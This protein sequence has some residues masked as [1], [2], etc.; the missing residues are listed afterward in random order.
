MN[1][2]KFIIKI[3]VRVGFI[4]ITSFLFIWV[5]AYDHLSA[6]RFAISLALILQTWALFHY[7]SVTNRNLNNFL[8][9]LRYL[10]QI[11]AADLKDASFDELNLTF[12]QIIDIVKKAKLDKAS[13]SQYFQSTVEHV[14]IGLISY[15]EDGTIEIFNQAALEIFNMD[16]PKRW[17]DF[18]RIHPEIK[19][20][21]SEMPLH[22]SML[23]TFTR[24]GS[25][26]KLS[27]RATEFKLQSIK[28]RLISL[29]NI[30]AELAL[31]ELEAWQKLIR[32]LTH[33]ITN[34]ITP[35]KSL[36]GT[37]LRMFEK[38]HRPVAPSSIKPETVSN[39]VVGLRTIQKQSK[40]L[41][42]FV[43]SYRSLTKLPTPQ[44]GDI[45]ISEL[46]AELSLLMSQEID[47]HSIALN[48]LCEP[49]TIKCIGDEKLLL[50][51]L[52]NLV[53]NAIAALVGIENPTIEIWVGQEISGKTMI[54]ISD[55][56]TGIPDDLLDQI[57]VPFYTTRAEGWGIGLSLSRQIMQLHKG[58]LEAGR[59]PAGHTVFNLNF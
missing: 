41:V 57:F 34:S 24:G 47:K 20:T 36:V 42:D 56:G 15:S 32:V 3:L 27:A 59:N 8:L 48:V 25:L 19:K 39:A 30:Q 55:N 21:L 18:E 4:S 51:V 6:T 17:E 35:I 52:I 29:Q 13:E 43:G 46:L 40:R 49:P 23:I 44:F 33:E 1:Y 38:D 31:G 16:R 28:K 26:L 22:E 45:Q 10:D 11:N 2:N 14:G 58:S 7:V 54:K 50:Q 37:V 53:K 12:N 5:M 9:S